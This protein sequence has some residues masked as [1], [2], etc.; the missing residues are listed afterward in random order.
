MSGDVLPPFPPPP[1]P[2]PYAR[3]YDGPIARFANSHLQES[4]Q[5]AVAG[6]APTEHGAVIAF[7]DGTTAKLAVVARRG[8]HWTAVG[9]LSHSKADGVEGEAAVRYSW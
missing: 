3:V 4:I 6:L 7:T 1:R 5:T 9:V 2:D 8:D